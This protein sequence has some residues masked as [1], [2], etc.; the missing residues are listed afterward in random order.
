MND[1]EAMNSQLCFPCL[2]SS[3]KI[4]ESFGAQEINKN[5]LVC[6]SFTTK[7]KLCVNYSSAYINS[8]NICV[9]TKS[10]VA[11]N[12]SNPTPVMCTAA[13]TQKTLT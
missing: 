11:V 3:A 4:A 10:I 5:L 1:G 2:L 6:I 7:P 8:N 9:K 12:Y 13:I